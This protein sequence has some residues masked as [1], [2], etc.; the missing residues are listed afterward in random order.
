[1]TVGFPKGFATASVMA[2]VLLL[3][4]AAMPVPVP[5]PVPVVNHQVAQ[6]PSVAAD[7]AAAQELPSLNAAPPAATQAAKVPVPKPPIP[8]VKTLPWIAAG[9]TVPAAPEDIDTPYSGRLAAPKADGLMVHA[10]PG[11]TPFGL[12]P[13]RV[14]DSDGSDR[15]WMPVIGSATGKWLQVL[16]PARR[17]LPSSGASVNG[18]TGWVLASKVL[19]KASAVT[20]D[21]DLTA[22]TVTVSDA[23]TVQAVFPVSISG[24]GE[25]A[26]GRSFVTGR[27][28]TS[29]SEKCSAQPM[30]I[31]SA[32]SESADG[33]FGQDTAVQAV[34]AFSEH[35]QTISGYTAA[36]PGCI[37]IGEDD[38]PRLLGLVPDGTPVS[39]HA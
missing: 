33:Y 19:T 6:R 15:T 28:T 13:A 7:P 2:A 8:E 11:G 36:T 17:N 37:I 12:L 23:G 39:V 21:V 29:L 35:C 1:M 25:T 10:S 30:M 16:L 32:Q 5:V 22:K 24:G 3:G 26:R 4:P 9:A 31:L 14:V 20:V 18:A 34:H 27:Y 38:I